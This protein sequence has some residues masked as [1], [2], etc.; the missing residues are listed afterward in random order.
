MKVFN[1]VFAGL[2]GC[3]LA[4]GA[5]PPAAAAQVK[6]AGPEY[7]GQIQKYEKGER[8]VA[9]DVGLAFYHGISGAPLNYQKAQ[10][11]FAKAAG[12]G[13]IYAAVK[14]AD[15]YI[16]GQGIP[17][18][19]AEAL[20]WYRKAAEAG[21]PEAQEKLGDMYYSGEAGKRDHSEAAKWYRKASEQELTP[22]PFAKLGRIY[23][24]ADGVKVDYPEALK[25][26]LKAD[27]LGDKTAAGYIADIYKADIGVKKDLSKSYEWLVKGS[28][29]GEPMAMN[30]LAEAY[31][32]GEGVGR[33][34]VE[35]YKWLAV[36]TAKV[37]NP[38]AELLL[39]QVTKKLSA[40]ELASAKK[41]ASALVNKYVTTNDREQK[42]YEKTLKGK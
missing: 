27:E 21:N 41:Q 23:L 20:K 9:F 39:A 5:F 35:A 33:N 29:K 36:V 18:S 42:A 32:S 34:Y 25:C 26:Y 7:L 16:S 12:N 6:T 19:K 31:F 3:V 40:G 2:I 10:E 24:I 30:K 1:S 15:M 38:S 13:D 28:L 37:N 14:L 22:G 4:A 8:G 11:W 17:I